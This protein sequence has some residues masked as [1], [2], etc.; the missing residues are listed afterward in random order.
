MALECGIANHETFSRAFRRQFGMLPS[1]Y[2]RRGIPGGSHREPDRHSAAAVA[3]YELSQTKIVRLRGVQV[4]FQRNIGPYETVK[5]SLWDELLEWAKCH[6]LA[7]PWTLLGIAQDAPGITPESKL[8]FDAARYAGSPLPASR[9][10]GTQALPEGQYAVTT[11]VGP[12]RVLFHAYQDIFRR[13]RSMKGV[14][15]LGVPAIEMYHTS[16]VVADLAVKHTDLYMPVVKR[17]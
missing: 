9:R 17:P 3:A 15:L 1:D 11:C 7:K 4:A 14:T 8:R 13:I 10:V 2:R 6:R 5:D 12:Y 16:R